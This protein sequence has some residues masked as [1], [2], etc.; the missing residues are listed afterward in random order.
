MNPQ[1]AAIENF[2]SLRSNLAAYIDGEL[3]PREELELEIHLAVCS[4]CSEELNEQK[5]LLQALNYALEDKNEIE[6]PVDFTRVVV[7]NAESKVSGL[8]RPQERFRALFVCAA[9][10]LLVLLSFGAETKTVLHA[11]AKFAD[12]V[13]AVG[14]FVWN[15][16]Y[17][18]GVGTAIILRSLS[19]QIVFNPNFPVAVLI[20]FFFV[21]MIFLS[22]FV[23]RSNRS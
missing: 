19:H 7:A 13:F 2:C 5:K 9:L 11:F 20:G 12:Q 23:L 22:R 16:I 18:V 8:R 10:L 6:L 15:L 1:N 17:D 14:G 3:S 4:T 21:S